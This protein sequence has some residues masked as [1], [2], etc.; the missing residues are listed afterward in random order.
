MATFLAPGLK[1]AYVAVPKVASTTLE[2]L[3]ADLAGLDR[4][5]FHKAASGA[6]TREQTVHAGGQWPRRLRV[7]RPAP[8]HV[9]RAGVDS[10]WFVFAVVRDPRERLWSAWQSKFLV[11]RR[12]YIDHYGQEPWFPRV[13][14]DPSDVIEDFAR[15][16]DALRA[17]VGDLLERDG[18]FKQQAGIVLDGP[19]PVTNLYGVRDMPALLGDLAAHIGPYG[20]DVPDLHRDNA[21]P[22]ELASEVLD[23]GVGEQIADLYRDDFDRLG[24]LW[25][26][27]PSTVSAESW[28]GA[29]FLDISSRV[30]LHERV[31]DLASY[32]RDLM[33]QRSALRVR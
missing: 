1:V 19:F 17:G 2:W 3:M 31:E 10:Q 16:V 18:H 8:E 22:L 32:A 7:A 9:E 27:E 28:P 14:H 15:F 4:G 26:E 13:P 6:P 21:T 33:A 5:R 29:A 20:A 23:G 25:P 24:H 11:R 30:A 12:T